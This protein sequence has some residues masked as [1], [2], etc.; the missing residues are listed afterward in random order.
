[1]VFLLK[2]L[3]NSKQKNTSQ[4]D[5]LNKFWIKILEDVCVEILSS[6]SSK[7]ANWKISKKLSMLKNSQNS[8]NLI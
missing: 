1:M 5:L 4:V 6:L 8:K 7:D 2:I 3:N